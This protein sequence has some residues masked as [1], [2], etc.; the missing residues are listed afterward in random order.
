MQTTK[1]IGFFDK[2][3][4]DLSVN[5]RQQEGYFELH[6]GEGLFTGEAPYDLYTTGMSIS[7]QNEFIIDNSGNFFGGFDQTHSIKIKINKKDENKYSYYFGDVL[8]ANDMDFLNTGINGIKLV[9][10]SGDGLSAKI[11][12]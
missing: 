12:K 7:G 10:E 11:Q 2:G 6:L 4:I 9:S 8:M 5:I 1:E 3:I